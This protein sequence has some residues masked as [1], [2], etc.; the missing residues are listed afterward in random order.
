MIKR[1]L[2]IGWLMVLCL[3]VQAQIDNWIPF[4]K[5]NSPSP[6]E[7]FSKS[8]VDIL[9]PNQIQLRTE[10]FVVTIQNKNLELDRT[11]MIDFFLQKPEDIESVQFTLEANQ[12]AIE[13]IKVIPNLQLDTKSV[14]FTL[15]QD[16]NILSVN[17]E[18]NDQSIQKGEAVFFTIMIRV[19]KPISMDQA[20]IISSKINK[21]RG[22]NK[23]GEE[24][25]VDLDVQNVT[26]PNSSFFTSFGPNPVQS[27][28]FFNCYFTESNLI[29]FY[30]IDVNGR[31]FNK[32]LERQF[33]KGNSSVEIDVSGFPN[34]IYYLQANINEHPLAIQKLMIHR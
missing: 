21:A 14:D 15:F 17:W 20:F 8:D 29:S 23:A 26:T 4:A 1:M 31:V 32:L 6:L 10:P 12:H 19:T 18:K 11:Y 2:A 5:I 13:I 28:L 34:G 33:D 16:Q 3:V 9:A 7:T 25:S 27:N 24:V 22:V 30:L